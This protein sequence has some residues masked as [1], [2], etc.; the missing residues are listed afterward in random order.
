MEAAVDDKAVKELAR[1]LAKDL[2]TDKD[3]SVLSRALKKVAVEAALEAEMDEHLGYEK[4]QAKGRGTG[5]SRNGKSTK[6]LKGDHGEVD[7]DVPRDRNSSF[8]PQLIKKGQSRVTEMDDQILFLYAKGMSTRD[9]AATFKEMYSADI[10]P[11]LISKVTDRVIDRVIEW[12]NR[13]LDAIYPIVYLDCIVLKIRQNQRVINK[14]LYLALGVNLHGHKELLGLW[15]AETEGA[16]FWLSVLTELKTRGLKDILIACVD[17]LKGFPDAIAAEYPDTKIQLCIVHMVRNSLRFVP[18]KDYKAVTSDLKLI[19]QA[20]TEADALASLD[21]FAHTWDD[22]YPQISKSWRENWPNLI[23][24]F[25]Y[26]PDIRK[27]I[28]TT[29]AIESLNSVIRKATR[30]RKV[31]PTD[32][33]ALKVAYLAIQEASKKWTMPIRHWKLALNR[34]SIEFGDRVTDHL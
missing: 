24:L 31:F 23:A 30:K 27:A 22:K 21:R 16:K 8:D 13:S 7:I 33:S 29:N 11:T 26:S 14:S 18:W 12:Q 19:Y 25:E 9:I 15:L 2:K 28:Y 6:R 32:Q 4:H 1:K 5:N 3:L 10:S 34:F 20:K 17:G